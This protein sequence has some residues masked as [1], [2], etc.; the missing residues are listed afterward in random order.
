MN[1]FIEC[2]WDDIRLND[3]WLMNKYIEMGKSIQTIHE[4]IYFKRESLDEIILQYP[5]KIIYG[6]NNDELRT[7]YANI[8]ADNMTQINEILGVNYHIDYNESKESIVIGFVEKAKTVT[9]E[10][11]E[12]I[13]T[14][15]L[16]SVLDNLK[17]YFY[18][19]KL[20]TY[21]N[22]N[23]SKLYFCSNFNEFF[24]KKISPVDVIHEEIHKIIDDMNSSI[25]H[26]FYIH[27]GIAIYMHNILY[28]SSD[29]SLNMDILIK[30]FCCIDYAL[31]MIDEKKRDDILK[32]NFGSFF[33]PFPHL[34]NNNAR[35]NRTPHAIGYSCILYNVE[36]VGE[37][38]ISQLI[39]S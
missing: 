18:Q 12:H 24:S 17:F 5:H 6:K 37:H 31:Y 14:M 34:N 16:F 22:P 1:N 39:N 35:R 25:N 32:N 10:I 36:T 21:H 11:K 27:E 38:I 30:Q 9:A 4:S 29:A 26:D 7:A 20:S 2:S 8:I 3:G 13:N 33:K 28:D 15:G 19:M 23:S